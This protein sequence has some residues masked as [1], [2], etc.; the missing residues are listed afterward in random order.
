MAHHSCPDCG[1]K[2]SLSSAFCKCCG[3]RI[4]NAL[5]PC[6]H[7]SALIPAQSTICPHC[8]GELQYDNSCVESTFTPTFKVETSDTTISHVHQECLHLSQRR[9]WRIAAI[10]LSMII[11]TSISSFTIVA[12]RNA[13]AETELLSETMEIRTIEGCQ[14]FLDKYPNSYSAAEVRMLIATL[15]E[16]NKAWISAQ[17][18]DNIS[19]YQAFIKQYPL[20]VQVAAGQEAIDSIV[21]HTGTFQLQ[22]IALKAYIDTAKNLYYKQQAKYVLSRYETDGISPTETQEISEALVAFFAA[23]N[24]RVLAEYPARYVQAPL[25]RF[26]GMNDAS[27][28][29]VTDYVHRMKKERTTL[30]YKEVLKLRKERVGDSFYYVAHCDVARVTNGYRHHHMAYV[31]LTP[32]YKVSAIGFMH[33]PTTAS[34]GEEIPS[35]ASDTGIN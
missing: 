17:K 12:Y 32:H 22:R 13:L 31:R 3:Y 24:D 4:A 10:L 34:V 14:A 30:V 25:S 29:Y 15:E 35:I 33:A 6:V 18:K 20:A 7:C 26:F 28:A 21:W 1:T 8:T 27:L 23:F 5:I 11:I 19:A 16:E 2:V 9:Q